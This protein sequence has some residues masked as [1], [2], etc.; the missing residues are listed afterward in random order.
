MS[1]LKK[2]RITEKQ[3]E[4]NS[5]SEANSVSSHGSAKDEK[6]T[7]GEEPATKSFKEL[8]IIDQLCEACENMGYKAPTPIQSQA[9]PLALEGRDVIGLAETG[10]GKTAAFA[11][12]MLQG[13][14][15]MF[16]TVILPDSRSSYGG[17]SNTLWSRSSPHPRTRIPDI[18][19]L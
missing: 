7:S 17:A 14:F 4:T 9:I 5:D 16:Y 11:L 19:S 6:Q 15:V 10:S 8:G 12:P 1:A 13:M 18:S 2:R 3:P